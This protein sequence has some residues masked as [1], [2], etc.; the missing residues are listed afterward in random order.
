MDNPNFSNP[1]MIRQRSAR[2]TRRSRRVNPFENGIVPPRQQAVISAH[3]PTSDPWIQ[4]QIDNGELTLE[5]AESIGEVRSRENMFR[6]RSRSDRERSQ[7]IHHEEQRQRNLNKSLRQSQPAI[8]RS[9]YQGEVATTAERFKRRM[10]EV[11]KAEERR[12][13]RGEQL[14]NA[15]QPPVDRGHHP[16]VTDDESIRDMM[17]ELN[18]GDVMADVDVQVQKLPQQEPKRVRKSGPLSRMRNEWSASDAPDDFD[19]EP[20][21]ELDESEMTPMEMAGSDQEEDLLAE[22]GGPGPVMWRET[23]T[24]QS[25]LGYIDDNGLD[26]PVSMK[27]KK[28]DIVEELRKAAPELESQI[29]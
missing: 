7:N 9:A 1:R 23:M 12:K 10:E 6:K 29:V 26:L 18:N 20:V 3:F 15:S 2:P 14:I 13:N 25:L 21:H 28:G 4:K 11:S 17:D 5:E 22:P 16:L 24:K 27:H 19:D 8:R